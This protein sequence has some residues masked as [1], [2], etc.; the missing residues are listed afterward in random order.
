[1]VLDWTVDGTWTMDYGLWTGLW[2]DFWSF[3]LNYACTSWQ[4]ALF[5]HMVSSKHDE[6]NPDVI[7]ISSTSDSEISDGEIPRKHK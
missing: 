7:F 6:F 5:D 3:G 1:M 4:Q 2:T